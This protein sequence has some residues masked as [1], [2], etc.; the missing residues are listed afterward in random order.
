MLVGFNIGNSTSLSPL[1][2]QVEFAKADFAKGVALMVAI[3][4][5]TY[6]FAP[7]AFCLLREAGADWAVFAAAI[8]LYLI[9]A[10]C[11][12]A[13]CGVYLNAPRRGRASRSG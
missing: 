13:G 11:Y 10:L 4:Q 8:A 5:G 9:A 1:I 2:A 7:V 12:L 3:G 6:T